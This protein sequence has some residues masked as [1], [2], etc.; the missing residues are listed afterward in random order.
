MRVAIVTETFTPNVNGVVR[1]V[2]EFTQY[3]QSHG[4]EAIVFAPGDGDDEA[5]GPPVVRIHGA[6]F[7]LYPELTLAPFSLRMTPIMREWRPDLVH[8]ASPFVLGAHGLKVARSLRVPVSA[9]YQTD[10]AAYAEYFGLGALARLAWRR[11]LDIHNA[12]DVNFAPTMSI[13][14][15]LRARGMRRVHIS[16]RGVD[17]QTFH[18][19]HRDRSWRARFT[20]DDDRPILLFV[21]RVSPE[22]N[23]SALAEVARALPECPMVIVGDGPARGLLQS[24]VAGAN[25]H[26]TGVLHG[27]DLATA[28]ASSDV[29]VFP[30]ESETFGQVVREAM[31]SGLPAIGVRAGGV[32]DLILEGETGLLCPP[33]N[34]EE[35][36][37]ATRRLVADAPVRRSLGAGARAEAER[38]TWDAVFDHLM[39][40]YAGLVTPMESPLAITRVQ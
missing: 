30:S 3:L 38:H 29:F 33:S 7:P 27:H 17:T 12:C 16:G 28:Y 23:L 21:G 32:Q 14:H 26:F 37:A 36:V 8:L 18:P 13:A 15:D 39:G 4:H 5:G 1:T 22:K 24:L 40:W 20:P 34:V 6:P 2:L 31:A 25:V 9:H 10:L 11:L 19:R 35:L